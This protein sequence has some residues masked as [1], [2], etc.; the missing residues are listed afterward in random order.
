MKRAFKY[1]FCNLLPLDRQHL[2]LLVGV[3]DDGL[4][5]N[6]QLALH[7]LQTKEQLIIDL[8]LFCLNFP[9]MTR[10]C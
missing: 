7:G 3:I 8:S 10:R 5:T 9:D 1:L 4:P 6:Q 2:L